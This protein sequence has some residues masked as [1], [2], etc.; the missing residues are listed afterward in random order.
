MLLPRNKSRQ[1]VSEEEFIKLMGVTKC[2]TAYAAQSSGVT[3][4]MEKLLVKVYTDIQEEKRAS[5]YPLRME[6]RK[7]KAAN[8][9]G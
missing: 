7:K 9:H 8:G 4:P 3:T 1:P 5:R 6:L 2:P